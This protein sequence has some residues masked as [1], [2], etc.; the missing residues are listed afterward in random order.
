MPLKMFH[1]QSHSYVT[2]EYKAATE[3]TE[4]KCLINKI[5]R[6]MR[7]KISK[8]L[9]SSLKK[10]DEIKAAPVYNSLISISF[11]TSFSF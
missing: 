1:L 4:L 9:N 3:L 6:Q 2:L 10:E 11:L 8:G 5:W 7:K